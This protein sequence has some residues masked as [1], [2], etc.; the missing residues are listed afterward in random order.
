LGCSLQNL[1][2]KIQPPYYKN[3]D[4]KNR[5]KDEHEVGTDKWVL[6]YVHPAE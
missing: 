3:N 1:A 6:R 5:E 4:N 2:R